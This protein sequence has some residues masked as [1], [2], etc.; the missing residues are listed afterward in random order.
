M[1]RMAWR[2]LYLFALL[3]GLFIANYWR[4]QVKAAEASKPQVT[5][6]I[7]P[8]AGM[9][10]LDVRIRIRVDRHVR[11]RGLFIQATSLTFFRSSYVQMDGYDAPAYYE[12]YYK[13]VPCG[14]YIFVV[15]LLNDQGKV[16]MHIERPAIYRG[17]LCDEAP[18]PPPPADSLSA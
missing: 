10:P 18:P 12:I 14:D 3:M 5:L 2:L 15:D 13:S 11:N 6:D 7:S 1:T 17:V 4:E 9:A 8:V 16:W